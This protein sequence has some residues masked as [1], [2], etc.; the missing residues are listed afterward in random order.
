M[1][2]SQLHESLGEIKG[3]LKLIVPKLDNL[4]TRLQNVETKMSKILGY[5]TAV[6]AV[7]SLMIVLIKDKISKWL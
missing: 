1:N 7:F 2:D 4:D 6:S 3:Q 5:A